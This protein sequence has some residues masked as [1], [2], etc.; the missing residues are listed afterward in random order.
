MKQYSIYAN[1]VVPIAQ[2]FYLSY[3]NRERIV[4]QVLGTSLF[5]YIINKTQTLIDS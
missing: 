3:R 2:Q 5:F 1:T 4:S